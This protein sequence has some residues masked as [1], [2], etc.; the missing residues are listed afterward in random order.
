MERFSDKIIPVEKPMIMKIFYK[1]EGCEK[2]VGKFI[3][4]STIDLSTIQG[5]NCFQS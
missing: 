2:A 4:K 5:I 3:L 1:L